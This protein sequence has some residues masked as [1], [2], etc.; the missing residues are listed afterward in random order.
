MYQEIDGI[1]GDA[2]LNTSVDDLC[3]CL[4]EKYKVDVPQLKTDDITQDPS[5]AQIDVSQDRTR[6]IFDRSRP[7]YVTGTRITFYVPFGGDPRMFNCRPSTYTT[8]SPYARIAGS[9]LLITYES[10]EQDPAAAKSFLDYNLTLTLRYLGWIS[11]DVSRH[12][13]SLREWARTKIE[14]RR[15]KLLKDRGMVEA[16]GIPLRKRQNASQTYVVPTVRKK[17][18]V[19]RPPENTAPYAP[20][21]TLD[22]NAYESILS[23]ISNMAAVIERSPHAF[24]EMGEE[25]LRQHF[26]VQL[27]GQYEGQATGETFNFQGKTDILI[28]WNGKNI[29]IAECKFWE[30]PKSFRKALDQLLGYAAWRD[31]KTA[32]LIFNRQKDF[33]AVLNKIPEVVMEHP[34]FKREL[35]Y[36]ESKTQSRFVL[37]HPGDQ[38]R[39]LMLTVM[40]FDMPR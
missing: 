14:A 20:E 22:E 19:S 33:S 10:T 29:F 13:N 38:N 21:P 11:G 35:P 30:G 26:L 6:V 32:L 31:T 24:R 37:H 4:E 15:D 9:D 23:I 18:S 8:V 17:L 1:N 39:E 40:A 28:R 12:N 7:T 5:E 2:F 16:L 34:N 25:D 27:N 3:D 36:G